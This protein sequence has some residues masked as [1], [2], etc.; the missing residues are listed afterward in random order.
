VIKSLN[1]RRVSSAPY[2]LHTTARA[3]PSSLDSTHLL[4]TEH[5][6][7]IP[8]DPSAQF[9][10]EHWMAGVEQSAEHAAGAPATADSQAGE[11]LPRA[12]GARA[13]TGV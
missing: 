8:S 4:L 9:D 2:M 11:M 10:T 1:L 3:A 7:L 13:R 6:T 12:R 5:I